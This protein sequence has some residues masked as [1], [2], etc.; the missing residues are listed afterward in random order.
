MGVLARDF[1]FMCCV[2]LSAHKSCVCCAYCVYRVVFYIYVHHDNI[3][4][5]RVY[6]CVCVIM[7][8]R[9]D[10]G[11]ALAIGK[12]TV[13]RSYKQNVSEMFHTF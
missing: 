13:F 11:M 5:F 12:L 8:R 7:I 3:K 10:I 9:D 2:Q 1:A 4:H 6:V